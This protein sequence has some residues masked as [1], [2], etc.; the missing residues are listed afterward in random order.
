MTNNAPIPKG[1]DFSS[2]FK[3]GLRAFTAFHTFMYRFSGGKL[4][5]SISSAPVLLLTTI[6]HRTGKHR[7]RPLVY[8]MDNDRLVVVGS[9][10]G[11]THHPAWVRN[12]QVDPLVIVQIGRRK[13]SMRAE[14]AASAERARLWP[15]L[16][17]LFPGFAEYQYA[18]SRELPVVILQPLEA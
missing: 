8:L 10:G 7:T 12:L 2:Q 6:G 1:R 11:A 3:I 4:L 5:R 9:A 18:T 14:I 13:L 16:V 17:A 15:K